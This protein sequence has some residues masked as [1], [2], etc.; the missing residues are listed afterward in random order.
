MTK[1]C[2]T[3]SNKF[4]PHSGRKE[5]SNYC[6]IRCFA[7]SSTIGFLCNKCGNYFRTKKFEHTRKKYIRDGICTP[8]FRSRPRVVRDRSY[9]SY[10]NGKYKIWRDTVFKRDNWTCRNCGIRGGRLEA[11]H[12]IP[13]V[14]NEI[15]RFEVWNG[16]TLCNSCHWKITRAQKTKHEHNFEKVVFCKNCQNY[17]LIGSSSWIKL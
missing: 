6:S 11:H 9:H 17:H 10:S 7:N 14:K 5:T 12:L 13:W 3:C 4:I 15:Y 1:I 16:E 8:C 2:I